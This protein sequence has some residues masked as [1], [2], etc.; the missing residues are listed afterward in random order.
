MLVVQRVAMEATLGE[1]ARWFGQLRA[2]DT[3][4]SDDDGVA[5]G[6]RGEENR[7]RR[8]EPQS[9]NED[10]LRQLDAMREAVPEM[11]GGLV[12]VPKVAAGEEE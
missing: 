8:D 9:I 3:L 7:L 5:T 10:R 1:V 11:E 2:I 4:L 12:K 6:V